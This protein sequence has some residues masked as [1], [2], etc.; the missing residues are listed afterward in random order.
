M[1][2]TITIA[3]RFNGPPGSGNGGYVCGLLAKHINGASTVTLRAPPPLATPLTLTSDGVRAALHHG[4]TLVAEAE[5]APFALTAAAPPTLTEA[6]HA[7]ARYV[8]HA[9]HRFD[10]C[11]VCGTN[12]QPADG[13][14]LF[15]GKLDGRDVVA[16][17]WQPTADLADPSGAI[18][19]EFI[20]AALDC[21]SYWALPRAGEMAALLARMTAHIDAPLPAPGAPLIVSAWP[22]GSDGRKHRAASAVFHADGALLARAEALWIEPKAA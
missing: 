9:N 6:E 10:T 20:H 1:R 5:A 12:R 3:P 16:S 19:A 13:L 14:D 17:P 15:T 21:P 22:L 2:E 7:A 4:D 18:A 11:F 8:G